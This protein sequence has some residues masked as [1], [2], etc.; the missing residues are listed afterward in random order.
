MQ[1]RGEF[2]N[3]ILSTIPELGYMFDLDIFTIEY[4]E[5]VV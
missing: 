2:R 3:K 1:G 5:R 4:S